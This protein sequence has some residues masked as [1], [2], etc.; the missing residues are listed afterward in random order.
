MR[1]LIVDDMPLARQRV[2]SCLA[3]EPDV[4]IVGECANGREAIE[5]IGS[6]QPDLVFLDVQMP[7]IGGFEVVE[8]VGAEH[9]LAVESPPGGGFVVRVELPAAP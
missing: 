6:L 3:R 8:A 5:A 4:E 9:A 1:T 7:Q 2:R